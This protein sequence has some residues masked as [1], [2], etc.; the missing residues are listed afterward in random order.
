[1]T[2]PHELPAGSLVDPFGDLI[3]DTA[4]AFAD[5][6]ARADETVYEVF[7]CI[8]PKAGPSGSGE[9]IGLRFHLKP[10]W[11]LCTF[12]IPGGDA[13][14]SGLVFL[15]GTVPPPPGTRFA[16]RILRPMKPEETDGTSQKAG[17]TESP[18]NA[19]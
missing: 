17:I 11:L 14:D 8:K 16:V 19:P 18:E 7:E 9:K 2:P 10:G 6:D 1:M 4:V 13:N 12:K 3:P 15:R 5:E